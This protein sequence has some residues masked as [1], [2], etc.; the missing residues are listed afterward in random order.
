VTIAS[1][2]QESQQLNNPVTATSDATGAATFMFQSP[3][4]GLT[5]TGT[6][7][8]PAATVNAVFQAT[9]GTSVWGSWGGNTVYGPVQAFAGQVL[10]V[11]AT[12]LAPNTQYILS[13]LGSS[14]PSYLVQP[15]MPQANATAVASELFG[16]NALA[17]AGTSGGVNAGFA[18]IAGNASGPFP[19]GTFPVGCRLWNWGWFPQFG[20]G[21]TFTAT[22]L[23]ILSIVSTSNVVGGFDSIVPSA[24]GASNRLA[25]ALGDGTRM[26][27][28]NFSGVTLN[29]FVT[30]STL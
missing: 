8:C 29:V 10:V 11:K 2:S 19:G 5:Y 21:T 30:Y 14:D 13:W 24:E 4:L 17:Q 20:G 6:L 22:P 25:G 23:L 27:I 9:I 15:A 7:S 26:Q 3:P 16:L 12:K 18:L 28:A 1:L